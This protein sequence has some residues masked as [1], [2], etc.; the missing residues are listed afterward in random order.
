MCIFTTYAFLVRREKKIYKAFNMY[1]GG[2]TAELVTPALA[3]Q[4]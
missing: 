3:P 4:F 2:F 1:I